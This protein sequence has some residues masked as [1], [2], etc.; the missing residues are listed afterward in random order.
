MEYAKRVV[1]HKGNQKKFLEN[2]QVKLGLNTEEFGRFL[3]V[4]RRTISDW[5]MERYFMSLTGLEKICQRAKIPLPKGVKIKDPFWY[6]SKGAKVGWVT[7]FKKYGRV[8]G[9][10]EYRKNKWYEWWEKEGKFKKHPIINVCFPIKIPQKSFKLSEF[11]GIVLG[12]GGITKR[13]VSVTLNRVDDKEFTFYAVNLFR[14]LFGVEP[15]IYERIEQNI[16]NVVVSRSRLVNFLIN[17]GL[18]IGGK[19]RQ[20]VDVPVWIKK[21]DCFSKACLRGLF[22][23]DGC[24]YIDK[25]YYKNK[26]YYNCA[27][28]F[29]NRS[30]PILFFFKTKLKQLGFHPTHNT[31]FSVSLRRENEIIEY[32]KIVGSSNPKHLN[33]FK[34]HL[35][36]RNGEVPKW[37]QRS[38]LESG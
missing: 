6:T 32:F 21:S 29:T 7:V 24:F 4:H 5:K 10:P 37:S 38:R 17:M 26:T 9:D 22:D 11:I 16:V 19:V 28:N 27:M 25:H 36:S 33:K 20:Q 14:E 3:G 35:K 34:Q 12:D 8:G 30:L 13:Q 15:S 2:N 18:K 1:F 31:E 23:T